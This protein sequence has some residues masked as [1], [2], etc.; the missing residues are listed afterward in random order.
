M[1]DRILQKSGGRPAL[2][3]TV[4]HRIGSKVYEAVNTTPGKE[5]LA[6]YLREAERQNLDSVIMEVSSHALVQGRADDVPIR[7]AAF[8]NLTQDHLDY[9]R[10]MEEYY[11]AKKKLFDFKTLFTAII[12]IDDEYGKRLAEE[13]TAEKS[14]RILTFTL[15][16]EKKDAT[17]QARVLSAGF[18]GSRFELSYPK[19]SEGRLGVQEFFLPRPGRHHIVDAVCASALA[20]ASGG[21]RMIETASEALSDFPGAP[22]RFEVL[23][24][25]AKNLTAICDYAHTPDALENLLRTVREIR[26]SSTSNKRGRIITVFGCGGDRDKGKRPL[27]GRIAGVMSDYTIITSDNPRNEDPLDIIGEIE[28]GIYETAAGYSVTADRRS[29]ITRAVMLARPGDIIVVA[30][31]G[32]ETYQ[33]VGNRKKHFDDREVLKELL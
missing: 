27:M 25:E 24:S 33:I 21:S 20:F 15:D 28:E 23:R 13:L 1:L 7:Y 10:T 4:T 12:N 3:G 29:A 6:V 26:E 30:G 9:H 16:E 11:A 5:V 19:P 8:L 32:H 2:I 31:K 17:F 18:E 22:G 14:F